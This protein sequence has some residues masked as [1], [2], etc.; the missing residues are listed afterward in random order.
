M[1]EQKLIAA[2]LNSNQAFKRLD[3]IFDKEI[4]S[5][6]GKILYRYIKN[7]YDIDPNA[8]ECDKEILSHRIEQDFPKQ[9]KTLINALNNLEKVSVPNIL[10]EYRRVQ[11]N[12]VAQDLGGLL[13]TTPTSDKIPQLIERLKELDTPVEAQESEDVFIGGTIEELL[14][15]FRGENLI[16]LHPPNLNDVLGGGVPPGTHII[17]IARPE[18]GKSLLAINMASEFLKQGHKVLYFGNEDPHQ[19]MRM[20]FVS[21]LAEMDL[22][23]IRASP[24]KAWALAE[25]RGYWNLVFVAKG[26]M[27]VGLVRRM[28]EEHEPKVIVV[29]QLRNINTTSSMARVEGLEYI[30]RSLRAIYKDVGAV[31]LSITQAGDSADDKIVLTMGDVDFSN[32]GIPGSADVMIG[33]GADATMASHNERAATFIKN[34]ISGDHSTVYMRFVPKLSLAKNLEVLF[35]K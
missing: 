27:D 29:D 34:K 23:A 14:E 35:Q 10:E 22:D 1:N 19:V 16:K 13:L 4:L 30:A 3:P 21:R 7:F 11:R 24:G 33:V 15:P 26:K 12:A 2:L 31:G 5:D 25:N 18:M 28:A 6:I 8:E 20:R 17:L 9:S 32:T